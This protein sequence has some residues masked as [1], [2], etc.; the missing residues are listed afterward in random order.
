MSYR[1]ILI[2]MA[3]ILSSHLCSSLATLKCAHPRISTKHTASDWIPRFKVQCSSQKHHQFQLDHK[4]VTLYIPFDFKTPFLS[5]IIFFG[6]SYLFPVKFI[7]LLITSAFEIHGVHK[8]LV[9]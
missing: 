1:G 9:K 4:Q 7:N 6:N 3:A 5:M 8:L 2:Y